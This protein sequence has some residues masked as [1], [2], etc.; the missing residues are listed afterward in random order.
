VWSL[1]GLIV[2]AAVGAGA[3]YLLGKLSVRGDETVFSTFVA[4]VIAVGGAVVGGVQDILA[5]L[6]RR[7]PQ[8]GGPSGDYADPTLPHP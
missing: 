4:C 6:D 7:F 2:G 8:L 1:G 5:Y 3:G